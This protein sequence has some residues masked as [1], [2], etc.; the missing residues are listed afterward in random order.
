MFRNIIYLY[1]S[2][3]KTFDEIPTINL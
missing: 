3:P 2:V 1:S